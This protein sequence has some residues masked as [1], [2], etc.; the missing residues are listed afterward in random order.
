MGWPTSG[1]MPS[2]DPV[3][4]SATGT[5]S[6]SWRSTTQ[7]LDQ[8]GSNEHAFFGAPFASH[9]PIGYWDAFILC[10][11]M[12]RLQFSMAISQDW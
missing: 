12:R 5:G 10:A 8:H 2:T 3:G 6:D 9:T 1:N 11:S 4:L 7:R